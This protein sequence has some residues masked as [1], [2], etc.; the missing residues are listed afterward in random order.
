MNIERL[1]KILLFSVFVFCCTMCFYSS[2]TAAATK[3]YSNFSDIQKHWA[4]KSIST[5]VQRGY[6][7]GYANGKFMPNQAITRAEFCTFINKLLGYKKISPLRYSDVKGNEWYAL[8]MGK[9]VAAGYLGGYPDGTIRPNQG[10]TRE[11]IASILTKVFSLKNVQKNALSKFKDRESISSWSNLSVN[12][13]VYNKYMSGFPD[14]TFRP[15]STVTRAEALAIV[16]RIVVNLYDT[17]GTYGL[18][19]DTYTI[20]E[21]VF[22][23]SSNVVLKNVVINGDLYLTEGIGN[24]SVTLVNVKA[25]NVKVSGGVTINNCDLDN[26]LI[27]TTNVQKL[28]LLAQGTTKIASVDARSSV[29]LEEANL[30]GTGFNNVIINVPSGAHVEMDGIFKNV[31]VAAPKVQLDFLQGS[32]DSLAL[33]LGARDAKVYLG[34]DTITKKLSIVNKATIKGRG[35]INNAE[36][37]GDGVI[38]DKA[39]Q[40]IKVAMGVKAKINGRTVTG[41]KTY[42]SGYDYNRLAPIFA[43]DYPDVEDVHS[44]GFDLLLKADKSCRAYYVVLYADDRVPSADEV[45]AGEDASGRTVPSDRR[46]NVSLTANRERSVAIDDLRPDEEYHVYV[47]LDNSGVGIDPPVIR[48]KATTEDTRYGNISGTVTTTKGSE[49]RSV[50]VTVFEGSTIIDSTTTN[51][52]GEYTIYDLEPGTYNL[53]FSKSSYEDARTTKVTVSAGKTKYVNNSLQLK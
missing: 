52:D 34:T 4:E 36:V 3:N 24:G 51:A 17:S 45:L 29:L 19:Y 33:P 37:F 53:L 40:K 5:W 2:S 11:E 44:R 31:N 28:R 7:D 48:V 16:D 10:I 14:K 25:R 47:V 8:D 30:A 20:A 22:I 1:R 13:V 42:S 49:L 35:I 38:F 32:M 39:P 15:A 26:V 6:I 46:G 43:K 12:T 21:N 50:K 18:P 41:S 27:E 23:N 9:A